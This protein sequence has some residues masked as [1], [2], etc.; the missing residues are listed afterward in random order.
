V[1]ELDRDGEELVVT[2]SAAEKAEAVRGDVRVPMS[3]VRGIEVVDDAVHAVNAYRKSVGAAWPGR[4]V[5]GTFRSGDRRTFAVVHH[6]TARGVRIK[7]EGAKFD[8]LL[9]GCEDPEGT[10]RRLAAGSPSSG[11]WDPMAG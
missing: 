10:A 3:S 11:S 5:I 6:N 4:F 9:V 1:A 2:L 7:L 8:E